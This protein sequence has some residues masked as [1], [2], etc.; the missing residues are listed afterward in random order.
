MTISYLPF[1]NTRTEQ[2]YLKALFSL[3][4]ESGQS[5]VAGLAKKLGVTKPTVTSMM[6]KLAGKKLVHYARYR[7]MR[8]TDKGRREALLVIRKHRLVEMFLVKKLN[9]GWE[10][11]H[12]L[13]EQLEHVEAPEFFERLDAV[14]QYP[15]LD[16]HG[17][18]IPDKKGNVGITTHLPLSNC[19]AGDTVQL[20]A[21]GD[22]STNFLRFLDNRDL[23]LGLTVKIDSIEPFAGSM[24]VSY[25]KR[26][27]ETLPHTVC[28][29]LLVEK[30]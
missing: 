13:A 2:D 26:R 24:V 1:M 21:L 20:R 5:T 19:A 14:L 15:T 22:S 12:D 4:G 25:G 18:P 30:H 16:P 28:E 10:E 29:N 17:E 9:F 7:P 3:S 6:K 27:F 8:L 23:R 11:V